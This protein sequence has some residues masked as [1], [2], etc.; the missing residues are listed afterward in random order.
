MPGSFLAAFASLFTSWKA[1][2]D[3]ARI[4]VAASILLALNVLALWEP[5]RAHL[6][7]S[8]PEAAEGD[9]DR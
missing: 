1:P 9:E 7:S 2:A 6:E 5:F 4:G 3:I 8:T